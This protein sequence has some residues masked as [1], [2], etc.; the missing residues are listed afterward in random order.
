MGLQRLTAGPYLVSAAHNG[1]VDLEG[2]K[3]PI[4]AERHL[5]SIKAAARSVVLPDG[6]V[7]T[8]PVTLLVTGYVLDESGDIT[9]A[10]G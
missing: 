1:D 8:I 2:N 4:I 10:G 3:L 5:E 9:H 6:A 7:V